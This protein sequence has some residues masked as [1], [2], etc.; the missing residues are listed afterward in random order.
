MLQ[1]E[2]KYQSKV[3]RDFKMLDKRNYHSIVRFCEE[4][5]KAIEALNFDEY[6]IL[7]LNFVNA[8]FE[9]ES[10][11]KHIQVANNVIE[12]SILHN[13]QYWQGEDIYLKTLHQKAL[14][15]YHLQEFRPT[16]HIVKELIKLKPNDK[17]YRRLFKRCVALDGAVFLKKIRAI[18]VLLF[19][20]AASLFIINILVI[21]SFYSSKSDLFSLLSITIIGFGA[22]LL[23]SSVSIHRY[24]TYRQV[25]DFMRQ[26]KAKHKN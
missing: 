2:T 18:G 4:H 23:G 8:L 20:L 9:T 25:S 1:K 7:E 3:F 17:E 6:F 13:V 22:I 14:A 11:K 5:R 16:L 24:K 10:Y 12:Q 26:V 15:H 19:L 21:E